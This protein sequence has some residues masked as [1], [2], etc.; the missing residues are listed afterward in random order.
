MQEKKGK[1]IALTCIRLIGIY[2]LSSI[3]A[4]GVMLV[5]SQFE[6]IFLA[7]IMVLQCLIVWLWIYFRKHKFSSY[8]YEISVFLFIFNS[9]I[10]TIILFLAKGL[11][12]HPHF[13]VHPIFYLF[14]PEFILFMLAGKAMYIFLLGIGVLLLGVVLLFAQ[15][16]KKKIW[17]NLLVALVTFSLCFYA[18]IQSDEKKYGGHGFA[19]MNG[20]SSTDFSGYH[21]YDGEKLMEIE[22][23]PP[24]MIEKEEDMPILDGAEACYPLYSAV[25]K[26]LYKDIAH[27]ESKAHEEDPY[28]NGKIVHF[29]NSVVGYYDLIHGDT[30]MMFGASPS[31]AQELYAKEVN[32]NIVRTPIGR[33][34]FVFFVEEDNPIDGL[35][36]DELRAI[37]H[38]DITNWKELGGKDE[39]ILAFQR[40]EDSGSQVVMK[41]FMQDISLKEPLSYE[42]V[43]AMV[44][45]IKEVKQ[46]HNEAGALG[47]SFHYFLTGLQQEKNVKILKV[48]GVYPSVETIADGSYPIC[49]PLICATVEGNPNP[50][51]NQVLEFLL[52]KQGQD[53]I[54][55]V[56][57]GPLEVKDGN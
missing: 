3:F 36:S 6:P 23:E 24:F 11:P 14:L 8:A 57:Y 43:D 15:I 32:K 55:K 39:E 54:Q 20:Y 44:G 10:T 25:A 7:F 37:Y 35:S 48:D 42:K 31:Q 34:A 19:Y 16:N 13:I 53:L 4:A 1:G 51:V 18:Y 12:N 30:D 17:P 2:F 46:Y 22:G 5:F 28:Q 47:Y 40:P 41:H 49:I 21:V 9:L 29:Y 26:A 27:I 56:G 45:V 50:Y 52:S 38:G 33:E